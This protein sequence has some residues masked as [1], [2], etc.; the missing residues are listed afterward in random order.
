MLKQKKPHKKGKKPLDILQQ[1]V[2]ELCS[3]DACLPDFLL[4]VQS[5]SDANVQFSQVLTKFVSPKE[6]KLLRDIRDLL[7]IAGFPPQFIHSICI[8][9]PQDV[10][11]SF[12]IARYFNCLPLHHPARQLMLRWTKLLRERTNNKSDMSLRNVVSFLVKV[13]RSYGL[14]F[15]Q[16]PEDAD[17]RIASNPMLLRALCSGTN[18]SQKFLWLQDFFVHVLRS[19]IKLSRDEIVN[20]TK[21]KR[22]TKPDD[23][24]V[25]RISANDLDILYRHCSS[26]NVWMEAMF[27]LMISTGMRV[28]ALSKILLR[29][30]SVVK[31]DGSLEMLKEGKTIEKGRKWFRFVILPRVQQLLRTWI[32]E[33]RPATLSPYL[34]AK[35]YN[36]RMTTGFIRFHF[37]AVCQKAGLC[38]KQFHPHGLRHTYA[39][40]L[41]EQGNSPEIVSKLLNHEN[42]KTTEQ[43]YLKESTLDVLRRANVPWFAAREEQALPTFLQEVIGSQNEENARKKQKID[44]VSQLYIPS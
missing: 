18:A 38:G 23:S 9:R 30:V 14:E 31:P 24:D 3:R 22:E 44:T 29:D 10:H 39:H 37:H 35:R 4:F 7:R 17:V 32:V 28:A 42:V 8:Q 16:F 43:Y 41:L 15:G 26:Y 20:V 12:A 2:C 13:C 11:H 19:E 33:F 6:T 25:H 40:M 36:M 27:L 5:K 1:V 21:T 34:W